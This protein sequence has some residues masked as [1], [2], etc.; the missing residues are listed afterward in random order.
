MSLTDWVS[1]ESG[2]SNLT[3]EIVFN[4]ETHKKSLR[5]QGTLGE[6]YFLPKKE[7][8]IRGQLSGCFRFLYTK[9]MSSPLSEVR[10]YC[11]MSKEDIHQDGSCYVASLNA[12]KQVFLRKYVNGLS[13]ESTLLACLKLPA[14]YNRGVFG[15]TW[16]YDPLVRPGVFFRGLLS[17]KPDKPEDA[18]RL[19]D[20]LDTDNPLTTSDG[21][22]FGVCIPTD[23]STDILIERTALHKLQY[24]NAPGE[25][26]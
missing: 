2:T 22:G 14:N 7:F 4:E 3:S 25:E 12:N 20:C 5:F 23:G 26:D 13:G 6:L 18:Y 15:L 24:T 21:E 8:N 16:A 19:F 10:I 9:K 17:V 1:H 11:M